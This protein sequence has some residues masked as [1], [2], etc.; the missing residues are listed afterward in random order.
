MLDPTLRLSLERAGRARGGT[1]ASAPAA[2]ATPHLATG[3]LVPGPC[4]RGQGRRR[5]S[6][7]GPGPHSLLPQPVLPGKPV[8]SGGQMFPLCLPCPKRPSA[9]TRTQAGEGHAQ[10]PSLPT[11]AYQS[12]LQSTGPFT[13]N[14]VPSL[15]PRGQEQAGRPEGHQQEHPQTGGVGLAGLTKGPPRTPV[16][17]EA[18]GPAKR[19]A[20]RGCSVVRFPGPPRGEQTAPTA[21]FPPMDKG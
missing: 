7:A 21:L 17:R 9:G 8:T 1:T 16:R 14:P 19:V 3:V 13:P 11:R 6:T 20:S 10:L 12:A 4:Q 18:Q 2:A 15:H 5:A